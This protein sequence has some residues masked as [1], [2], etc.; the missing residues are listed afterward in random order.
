M[1]PRLLGLILSLAASLPAAT[2]PPPVPAPVS[3]QEEADRCLET[4]RR[5]AAAANSLPFT[6]IYDGRSSSDL[7]PQWG[8]QVTERRLDDRRREV[9]LTFTDPASKLEVRC[10]AVAYANFPVVE[11]TVHFRNGG[12]AP[13]PILEKIRALDATWNRDGA[14]EFLLHHSLGTFFPFSPTDFMP[15][16]TK[17]EPSQSLRLIPLLGR[18][19]G[20]VMPYFNLERGRASGVIFAVGWPGAWVA[21]FARDEKTAIHVTAGQ[22]LVHAR[23]EP[24]EEIRSPLM[25]LLFWRGDWIDGQNAW[26]RWMIAHN[27]PPLFGQPPHPSLMASSS[28]QFGEMIHATEA[29]QI[30]FIDRY[31]EEKFPI[32]G[33]WMDAGWYENAGR[34][35][36]PIALRVDR[37]RFPRG[38]R[39]ITDHA[40]ARGL[41]TLLWFEPER[42]M[43]TNELFRDHPDWLFP[44]LMTKR[45]S[46][47]FYLG[48]PEAA[49]WLTDRVVRIL[50]DEGIDIYRNDFNVVEP[51]ELWRSHDTPDRQGLTENHHVVGYLHYF[52]ELRRRHP[53]LVIDSCAGGGSRNDLETMRRALP[54]YRSD[55]LFDPE[56]NQTQSY[57]LALWLPFQGT[58]PDPKKFDGYGL[59]SHLACPSVILPWDLRDRQLPYD[60]LRRAVQQWREYS[61]NYLGDFYPL[62]P[63]SL[64]QDVWVAWQFNRPEAGRGVVQ[65]FRRSASIYEKAHVT[66]RGLEPVARYRIRDLDAPGATREATGQS[67]MMAGLDLSIPSRPG[68]A[69][70]VYERIDAAAAPSGSN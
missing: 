29:N 20:G 5:G 56:S 1:Q 9:T 46:R 45:L 4:F 16:Q 17:L 69:I 33:W 14:D 66:L 21:E 35:Q 3:P 38:L 36:E 18:P 11:W 12:N 25:A 52:D 57:G 8:G 19:S 44:N 47:L 68:T 23:L 55:Y 58:C 53:G 51:V 63:C 30:E 6:F 2:P 42:I 27:L 28:A 59:R 70:L 49:T 43:P 10:V 34:W 50:A 31:L 48:N 40:H 32:D 62:T 60:D 13:T 64:G 22:E 15:Q 61:P 39:A 67:L 54:F 24:G 65:A 7:L 26:R 41:K 37:Q